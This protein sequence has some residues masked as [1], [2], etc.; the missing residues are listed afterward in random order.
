MSVRS[1][2]TIGIVVWS[3]V[4]IISLVFIVVCS[5]YW[6]CE[7]FRSVVIVEW[8]KGRG[9]V[10]IFLSLGDPVCS[11]AL[12]TENFT[13]VCC[14]PYIVIYFNKPVW[15][16]RSLRK[17]E[18]VLFLVP[19]VFDLGLLF[20][21]PFCIKFGD[22][23]AIFCG[24]LV[25]FCEQGNEATVSPVRGRQYKQLAIAFTSHIYCVVD[26]K[27]ESALCCICHFCTEQ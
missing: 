20:L 24:L 8:L 15:Q 9:C 2:S 12:Q 27:C 10:I 23:S 6:W 21:G 7:T 26:Q 4:T 25:L 1:V 14:A 5:H 16:K 11:N 18:R 19:F 17:T 13:H 3:S 22:K